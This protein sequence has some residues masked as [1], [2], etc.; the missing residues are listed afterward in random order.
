MKK[1]LT[2]LSNLL[3]TMI[4]SNFLSSCASGYSYRPNVDKT[5]Y[6]K[7]N[8]RDWEKLDRS[9]YLV[10]HS[11]DQMM[12][13]YDVSYDKSSN[14]IS[15]KL[16]PFQGLPLEEYN[17]IAD[18]GEKEKIEREKGQEAKDAIEQVHFMVGGDLDLSK[19]EI[20]FEL[21]QVYFIG[22]SKNE[23]SPGL[24]ALKWTGIAAGLF[25]TYYIIAY[26]A[27]ATSSY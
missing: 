7:K 22:V 10:V 18:K 1:T 12:E 23:L 4:M 2:L 21:I 6:E 11:G 26:T 19:T 15:G 17:R 24:K 8:D 9:N 14:L 3:L 16:R 25:V 20:S 27:V 5:K 13:L